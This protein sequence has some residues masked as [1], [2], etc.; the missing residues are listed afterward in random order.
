M[1]V[2]AELQ[3]DSYALSGV[4]R[5]VSICMFDTADCVSTSTLRRSLPEEFYSVSRF[6]MYMPSW[7]FAT[8]GLLTGSAP[9]TAPT[10]SLRTSVTQPG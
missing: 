5:S 2:T 7:V 9:I 4:E 1:K 10:V 6:H 3:N 8:H